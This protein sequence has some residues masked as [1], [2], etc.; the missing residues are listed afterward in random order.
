MLNIQEFGFA[1]ELFVL[2]FCGICCFFYTPAPVKSKQ[3]E[4]I[5]ESITIEEVSFE[6]AFEEIEFQEPSLE[7]IIETLSWADAKSVVSALRNKKLTSA[8]LAGKGTGGTYFQDILKTLLGDF[9]GDVRSVIKEVLSLK[10][11][12]V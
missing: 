4:V 9:E 5:E 3:Q 12:S 7:T 2:F 11:I 1:V 6:P 10:E 8:K